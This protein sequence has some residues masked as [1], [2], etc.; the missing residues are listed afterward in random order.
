MTY[1]DPQPRRPRLF[2]VVL[3]CTRDVKLSGDTYEAS[4]EHWVWA[5]ESAEAIEKATELSETTTGEIWAQYAVCG[6]DFAEREAAGPSITDTATTPDAVRCRA[7]NT[8]RV[9]CHLGIGHPGEHLA[10]D[11]WDAD[12]RWKP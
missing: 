6:E 7:T 1:R 11:A 3:S 8:L 5:T 4:E 9:R 12:V 2:F 10:R